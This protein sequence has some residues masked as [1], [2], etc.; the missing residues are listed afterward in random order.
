MFNRQRV[1]TW[2]LP[3]HPSRCLSSRR[4]QVVCSSRRWAR[5][6]SVSLTGEGEKN[7]RIYSSTAMR[8]YLVRFHQG[9]R[10][11]RIH[12]YQPAPPFPSGPRSGDPQ[13]TAGTMMQDVAYSLGQHRQGQ[14]AFARGQQILVA[15]PGYGGHDSCVRCLDVH[16]PIGTK[17]EGSRQAPHYSALNCYVI[18]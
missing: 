2:I 12:A 11:V 9:A 3:F 7:F 10:G 6:E 16:L 1:T 8:F 14:P 18:G 5:L 4:R 13:S 17:K 15:L